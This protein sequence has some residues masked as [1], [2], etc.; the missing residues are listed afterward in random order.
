MEKLQ[1]YLDRSREHPTGRHWVDNLIKPTLL[2][3]HLLRAEREGDFT[4][5]LAAIEG[6]LPYFFASGH[7]H[8]ARYLTQHIL[9][10]NY[11]IP[12]EAKA[13]L[14]SGAFV[15]RHQAGVWN[16]VSS[17]QFGEQTAVRIGK[18]GL[19]GVT[20]SPEHVKEWTDSFPITAYM[21]DTLVHI[22][23]ENVK[24]E[25]GEEEA[26]LKHKEESYS[27]RKADAEDR[28]GIRKELNKH[29][30]PLND[31]SDC[32]YNIVT[33][34]VASPEINVAEATSTGN[35]MKAEFISSLPDHFHR[36]ISSPVKTME[37]MKKGTKV[38][39]S[40]I[41]NMETIF[42]RF[43][44][45]GQTR[46]MELAPIFKFELC[47]VP[48]SLIDEFGCLRKGT[49]STLVHKLC[50]T[51]KEQLP[52]EMVIIDAQQL[53]YHVVWPVGGDVKVL[54]ASM[55]RRLDKYTNPKKILV[56][57]KYQK[58]SPKD[59]ERIRR[60][61]VG[62]TDYNLNFQTQLPCR[63]AIMKNKN[64]KRQLAALLSMCEY[65]ERT[66]VDSQS[67]GLHGHDEADVTIVSYV[68]QGASDGH[69]VIRVLSDDTDIFVL[70]VYWVYKASI[71][72]TVQME[73]WQGMVLS[74]N[75]TCEELGPKCL[76]LL[77]M[78]FLTG[79]DTTSYLY[80]KGKPSA[81]KTLLKGDFD[82]LYTVLGEIGAS[83][84]DLMGAGEAFITALYGLS[85][86]ISMA[87]AR[88]QLYTCKRG[89]RSWLCHQQ[90]QTCSFTS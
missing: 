75:A 67:D 54:A 70:L 32:L 21:S 53:L 68:I 4:L 66:I 71:M 72:A 16:S 45:I 89:S 74:I 24:K 12:A 43:I 3:H 38:G 20:L 17:D 7:F 57:D 26:G 33:G 14:A 31:H 81:L 63:E 1:D 9:E 64:N 6:L 46:Q 47:A 82:G 50:V 34:K 88:Y 87:D 78:H 13:E 18:G 69:K 73:N 28:E 37:T 11:L 23:L 85:P 52:A 8:Y 83:H 60:A 41:Y 76:Q 10:M 39:P 90:A 35:Q 29:S 27:R 49:K 55:K 15:C 36:T 58:L 25:K 62:S 51:Q 79:S 59:R 56:F 61:G 77:G 30:H 42:L 86:G 44:T 22:Y 40:M 19:K 5:Q 65:G 80:G 2:I 48:P 84:T